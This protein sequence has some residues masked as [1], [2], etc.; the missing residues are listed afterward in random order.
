MQIVLIAIAIILLVIAGWFGI[1]VLLVLNSFKMNAKPKIEQ[2]DL[3]AMSGANENF[4][5]EYNKILTS[6]GFE[7]SGDY[8]VT[9]AGDKEAKMRVFKNLRE[10]IEVSLY[11]IQVKDVRKMMISFE[12]YFE[13]GFKIITST[14]REPPIL[15][16]KDTAVYGLPDKDVKELIIFHRQRINEQSEARKVSLEK[17]NDSVFESITDS[18]SKELR[19]Q[20]EYGIFKYDNATDTY[21]FT[22]YGAIRGTFQMAMFSF[23]KGSNKSMFDTQYRV[24][25]KK[26]ER[27]KG[28]NTSGFVFMLLGLLAFTKKAENSAV[29]YF[30]IFSIL[31][32]ALI[33]IITGYLLRNKEFK[34]GWK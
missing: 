11:Q 4:Y 18:Y 3:S 13:D 16:F 8:S 10:G 28:I 24:K 34:D 26:K 2:I 23:T 33:V 12:T 25:N 17:I 1:T 6:E 9:T 14:N 7:F 31:F 20:L 15:K 21:K 27:L 29:L 32:G 5:L 19:E 30:R 22:L